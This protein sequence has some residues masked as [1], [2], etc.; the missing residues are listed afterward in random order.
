MAKRVGVQPDVLRDAQRRLE[1]QN[2]ERGQYGGTALGGS[3]TVRTGK[4]VPYVLKTPPKV[5]ID[6]KA[7]CT[8]RDIKSSTLLR[9]LIHSLLSGP[10][11][12]DYVSNRWRYRGRLVTVPPH[13][14]SKTT[15]YRLDSLIS[16]GS[17][18]A[19]GLRAKR[20][21]C[22]KTALVRGQVLELLE[23]KL[24]SFEIISG[25]MAM[26]ED[27]TKYWTGVGDD[28]ED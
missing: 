21:G 23:G 8:Y 12:P 17:R 9:S 14:H 26:H 27:E 19:L 20:R 24:S 3:R 11:D 15:P 28:D 5:L 2:A 18:R 22:T 1:E 25:P 13:E 6:W 10:K 7:Y 16:P 4:A